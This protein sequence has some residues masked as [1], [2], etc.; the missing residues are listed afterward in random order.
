M[1]ISAIAT[2]LLVVGE[3]FSYHRTVLA[4]VFVILTIYNMIS[5]MGIFTT[6]K[7]NYKEYPDWYCEI[8][9]FEKKYLIQFVEHELF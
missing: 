9:W 7:K 8:F 3:M 4:Y 5:L 6:L 2:F 1:T